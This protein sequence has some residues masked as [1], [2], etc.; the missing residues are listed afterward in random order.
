M[1]KLKLV[2]VVVFVVALL[3][4]ASAEAREL[5]YGS[6]LSPK[7]AINTDALPVF[8]KAVA[9]DTKGAIT[10]KMVAG[11]ALVKGR[12]TLAGIRDG[13]IDAGLAISVYTAKN[14]PSTAMLHS[15]IVGGSDNAATTA[16]QNETVLLNCPQCLKEWNK[17]NTIY[18]AGYAPTPFRI[19]C[20]KEVTTLKDFKGKKVR[21]SGGS[22]H[23][24]KLGGGVPVNMTP[25]EA[26]TALQR[27]TLDCVHGAIGWLKGYSYQDVAKFVVST[28]MGMVGPAVAMA[29]NLKTWRS[30]TNAQREVHWKYLPLL[31]AHSALTAYMFRDNAI[32]KDAQSVG[33]KITKGGAGF[34][35]VIDKRI[36]LQRDINSK[37]FG[38]FGVKNPGKILDA[39]DKA[40]VKWRK[41]SKEV[42][43]DIDKWAAALKREVYDKIDPNSL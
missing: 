24:I 14:T 9:K 12:T 32:L 26:T 42:G 11:G 16:A 15:T 1:R 39:Y 22:V 25:A 41:I 10:W 8:F 31:N 6:W 17:N 23:M 4:A 21:G 27:G 33:V 18:L 36:E 34:Q 43:T 2:A 38:K 19:M 28:P 29:M 3:A 13:L 5:V 30:M 7:H 35:G 37:R 20:R 40:L